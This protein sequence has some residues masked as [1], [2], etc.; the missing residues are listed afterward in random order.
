MNYVNRS[1]A[2]GGTRGRMGASGGVKALLLLALDFL[3][4]PWA[5]A[6][7]FC[8]IKL[9]ERLTQGLCQM[10]EDPGAIAKDEGLN[11][12]FPNRL[13]DPLNIEL[14]EI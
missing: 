1:L 13:A 4:R 3:T 9:T 7:L 11:M 12:I 10:V 6:S 2:G 8:S 5:S 14:L